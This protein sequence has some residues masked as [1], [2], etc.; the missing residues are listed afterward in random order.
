MKKQYFAIIALL[1]AILLFSTCTSSAVNTLPDPRQVQG[2]T[3]GELGLST[4]VRIVFTEALGEQG[5][6]PEI[7]PLKIRPRVSG[8]VVWEDDWTLKFTPDTLYKPDTEYRISF[9]ADSGLFSGIKSFEYGCHT[10][11]DSLLL[12]EEILRIPDPS[13][14]AAMVL[15]CTVTAAEG[16]TPDAVAEKI[17][18]KL[19]GSIL[20]VFVSTSPDNDGYSL[21]VDGIVKSDK[22]GDLVLSWSEK[23]GGRTKKLRKVVS[24]PGSGDFSV[25][26]IRPVPEPNEHIEIVFSQ[27]L[28]ENQ[29]LEGLVTAMG[30]DNPAVN[31]KSNI[32]RLYSN[33]KLPKTAEVLVSELV[34]SSGGIALGSDNRTTVRIPSEKPQV[35][36]VGNGVI[37]PTSQ[38]T[39]V[40][41]ETLNLSAF[42]V[43]AVKIY[44]DNMRQFLQINDLDGDKEMYRVG[45]VV[46]RKVIQL[47]WDDE[48][49]DRWIRYGLDVSPLIKDHPDGMF[50][51]RVTFRRPYIKYPGAEGATAEPVAWDNLSAGETGES[52]FWDNWQPNYSYD[53]RR[54]RNDPNHPAYY[55]KWND[56]DISAARNVLVSNLGLIVQRGADAEVMEISASD[57]RT[58]EPV[59]SA[60]IAVLNYQGRVLDSARTSGSGTASL[61]APAEA[62]LVTAS[63]GSDRAYV[64]VNAQSALET[65]QFDIK[66]VKPHKGVYGFIYGDRGVWRPG[67][68]AHMS[69]MLHDPQRVIPH[70]HPVVMELSDPRGS[71]RENRTVTDNEGGLYYFP[72]DFAADAPT[73][74]W[75]MRL[76]LGGQVFEKTVKV[77]SVMP[78]RLKIMLDLASGGGAGDALSNG[79]L[80]GTLSSV[81]LHGAIASDL[82]ASVDMSFSP[83]QTIF[84]GYSDYVFDDPVGQFFSDRESIFSGNLNEDGKAQIRK[85]VRIS[86]APGRLTATASTRV[87]ENGG[88]YSSEYVSFPF[89]PYDQYAGIKVPKGDAARGMLL[90][91]E[92]QRIDIALLNKDGS[93]VSSG[94]VK[95]EL[96]KLNW[97]WWWETDEENLSNFMRRR[98]YTV[99]L[100]DEIDINNGRG[101][102]TFQLHYPEWGRYLIRATDNRSGHVTGKI[103]YIDWPGWAGK[104]QKEGMGSASMLV[105]S[106]DKTS[107]TVGEDVTVSFPSDADGKALITIEADQ[108]IVE[109]RWIDTTVNSTDYTFRAGH[110]MAPNIYVHVLYVQPHM[111]T[112]NDRPIRTYGVVPVSVEDPVTVIS[113]KISTDDV[114]EPGSVVSIRVSEE[115]GRAMAYTLA[116]VDEGLLGITRFQ[117][118]DPRTEIYRRRASGMKTWD[119]Y[120][121]V[122]GAYS[123]ELNTLLAVGGGDEGAGAGKKK[124]NRFEPVALFIPP[125]S[126]SAGETKVHQIK[127]PQYVG[128]VRVML[129]AADRGAYGSAEK[130]V[131]VKKDLMVVGTAPRVVSPN[132]TFDIPVSLFALGESI[133]GASLSIEVQGPFTVNMSSRKL[134]SIEK[135]GEYEESF[136]VSSADSL[137]LGSI[138]ITARGGG[139]T[140]V[141]RIPLEVRS[142]APELHQVAVQDMSLDA[143]SSDSRFIEFFG[144]PGSNTLAVEAAAIPPMDL[145][146]R[147]EYLIR[148]P[149]GCIEQ[150]VS[151]VFPQLFLSDLTNL[152]EAEKSTARANIEAG[153]S[154]LAG[155]RTASGGFAYWPGQSEDSLWGTNYAGHFMLEAKARGYAVPSDLF[156]G[157]VSFQA[158]KA[159][160]AY[161]RRDQDKMIQAYRLYTLARAGSPD[162]AAMN[163]LRETGTLPEAARWRLAAAY[164]I[165]GLKEDGQRLAARA[166]TD[167]S[168]YIEYSGTFGNGD[169]DRA[170]ILEALVELGQ[171]TQAARLA[172]EISSVMT[173]DKSLST[174]TCAYG[175][176]A[177]AK[178]GMEEA[179]NEPIKLEIT[180]DGGR[181]QSFSTDKPVL[182]IPIDPGK[183][184]NGTLEIRNNSGRRIYP[185][186]LT[187]G[188]PRQGSE[189][190]V[191]QGLV[192]S[193]RY[194]DKDGRDLTGDRFFH[195][196]EI[197]IEIEVYNNTRTN[198]EE[199]V[200]SHM[201]PAGFEIFNERLSGD[202]SSRADY[203]YRDIR[204]DRV[205]TY[206]D[207]EGRKRTTFTLYV[208]AGYAGKFYMP[209]VLTQ[210]MYNPDVQ[211]VVPGQWISIE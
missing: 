161:P 61:K 95:V 154:R 34:Q 46:W 84:P 186:I 132:E 9:S 135:P 112:V 67:D 115:H 209:P 150:T 207:L 3:G 205:Y 119:I 86:D 187:G 208:N 120:D 183:S 147:L 41:I 200:L 103:V 73:G 29:P 138:V 141:S 51:L 164:G 170:F 27:P 179:K 106:A 30:L 58:A 56:H 158:T 162:F 128:A 171:H 124:Q 1:F 110:N 210:A 53:Y 77:E 111:Q 178:F 14:P 139:Y 176:L 193:I 69:F 7:N 66:G 117:T 76:R 189:Q 22:T 33:H 173:S 42:M 198:Y 49:T 148:Y 129:V 68:T 40:P 152:T 143:G 91:D 168:S 94:R 81:W 90:T 45:D 153:I 145:S 38:G 96:I 175:L 85:S 157:W 83:A 79:I 192:T 181:R 203:D 8:S 57:L 131:P 156:E 114:F 63:R 55:Q 64:K 127:L 54:H 107:C 43:E 74:N 149:H 137:G 28:N 80:S 12:E 160:E 92:D 133:T 48:N 206:F 26:S 191:N 4:P 21:N 196:D 204:D 78:N 17:E 32:V 165:A 31:R 35:R 177:M 185:R 113:P 109:S 39:T 88:S 172:R 197:R 25:L 195:G 18:A 184:L 87:Y 105:L 47:D 140:A 100:Q 163:R 101:S 44:G 122:A 118:P 142:P 24:V 159:N 82:K 104:G 190:A 174:Q 97:R 102:W 155:F 134:L 194:K 2:V 59:R 89:D 144:I 167:V 62:F 37:I 123:G 6:V 70:N 16:L 15:S 121:Y 202:S 5:T 116:V 125:T 93:R 130:E 99:R 50:Q 182:T 151:S 169:R 146:R 136:S 23:Q 211:S 126:I 201:L 75:T 71:V 108:Q 11:S 166:G 98:S 188:V 72:I 20:P 65:S 36:F 10:V 19:D 199:L 13:N 60:E 180:W 52:S